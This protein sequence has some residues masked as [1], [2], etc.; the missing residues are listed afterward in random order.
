MKKLVSLVLLAAMLLTC[1]FAMADTGDIARFADYT[2]VDL[3]V[4]ISKGYSCY[5]DDFEFSAELSP[6]NS[7]IIYEKDDDTYKITMDIKVLYSSGHCTLI[8]RLIFRREG[9]K[10][11][12]DDRMSDVY[13]RNGGNRYIIDT[14]GC[15]RSTSSKDYTATDSSV[16][17]MYT[18]GLVMLEDL[19]LHPMDI[20]VKMGSYC[21][22]F[23]LTA[24]QKQAIKA[25]YEDCKEAGVFD[26]AF[27]LTSDDYSI[28]TLFNENSVDA[29]ETVVEEEPAPEPQE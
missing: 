22:Q 29:E 12:F 7:K 3:N 11:Y 18:V 5:Y 15:S 27:L 20:E 21:H 8:P 24:E 16:E 19:A 10:T 23:F 28:R 25:F 4:F 14:T 6:Q 2:D 17:P 13:I 26:Q 9:W 1:S